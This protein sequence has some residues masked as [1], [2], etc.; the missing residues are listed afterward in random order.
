MIFRGHVRNH[1]T[2]LL[3]GSLALVLLAGCANLTRNPVP[4]DDINR[5]GISGMS[6]VRA[7]GGQFSPDFQEDLVA[8]IKQEPV[9]AFPLDEN[10]KPVYDALAISGGGSSGA[11]G[12]GILNGWTRTDTRPTFKI[13]TGIST[14]A[15]IAPFAFLGSDYDK[16]LKLVFTTTR[17]QDI[18]ER[19]NI[20]RALFRGEAFTQTTP[21]KH[22]IETH[23]DAAF[24]RAVA[25]AHNQGRRL[26]VGTT[27]M[28]AQTLVI[29]N[30]GVIANSGHPDTLELF[31]KVILASASIPAAFPPV[32]IEVEV[33]GQTY[34]EM[35]ADGGTVRQVF[36]YKGTVDL[37]AAAHEAKRGKRDGYRGTVYIIRN[38]KLGA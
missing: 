14:G 2:Q 31:Q 8:S 30:M 10:G 24:L 1:L 35:H 26:Y 15:L 18:L 3:P 21:L 32:F 37:Q 12:A 17:T 7:M 36:F 6:G 34:D 9:G 22:L 27:N 25:V 23:F 16:Q 28:D 29:W 38:G 13:V 20:F 5:A 11:F 4:V 33:D 19:L